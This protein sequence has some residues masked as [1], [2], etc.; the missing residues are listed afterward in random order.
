MRTAFAGL[1]EKDDPPAAIAAYRD[2]LTIWQPGEDRVSWSYCHMQL[3]SL[4]ATNFPPGS[5]EGEEAI[6]HLEVAVADETYLAGLLATLYGVRPVGDP[7]EN[8]R[9]R[10]QYL[11]QDVAAVDR[12]TEKEKWARSNNALACA[13]AEEP[14]ANFAVALEKQIALH[15]E[16]LATLKETD[17]PFAETC[18]DLGTALLNRTEGQLTENGAHA[19]EYLRRALAVC[20]ENDGGA[21]RAQILLLLGRCLVFKES[22]RAPENVYEALP[23]Y[24]EA[25]ALDRP[26]GRK[27][28]CARA[29][30][31]LPPMPT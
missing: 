10:I 4:L 3:G 1:A 27:W 23:L 25:R 5:P 24:Q 16:V 8:W 20:A 14:G 12:T 9:R 15:L 18:I 31:S 28:S 29:W 2:A 22:A 7:E 13:Y 21:Q 26:D 11:Q 6:A 30:K 19:E 17:G